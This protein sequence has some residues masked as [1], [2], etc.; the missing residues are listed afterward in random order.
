MN[1]DLS[2]SSLINVIFIAAGIGIC[3]MSIM[4]VGSGIHI[5][6]EVKGYFQ[7]FFT[8]INIYISMHLIRMLLEGHSGEGFAIGIRVVTFTEFLVSGLMIYMLSF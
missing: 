7:I 3:S 8:L 5:R 6:K 1:I 4:Q 2:F